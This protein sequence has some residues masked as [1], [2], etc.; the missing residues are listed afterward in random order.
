[1]EQQTMGHTGG[2]HRPPFTAGATG[3]FLGATHLFICTHCSNAPCRKSLMEKVLV[4]SPESNHSRA[5]F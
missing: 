2:Y 1:M 4:S 5:A 3:C